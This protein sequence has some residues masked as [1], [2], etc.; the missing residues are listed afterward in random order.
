MVNCKNEHHFSNTLFKKE[1]DANINVNP[2]ETI[3]CSTLITNQ[4]QLVL[5]TKTKIAVHQ[6]PD[7]TEISTCPIQGEATV[8]KGFDSV[9]GVLFLGVRLPN[10]KFAI[11]ILS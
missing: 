11:N 10:N 7:L 9:P 4:T 3:L 2:G 8:V 6:L 1:I 5:V